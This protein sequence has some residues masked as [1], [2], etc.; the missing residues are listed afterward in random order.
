MLDVF[1]AGMLV[2]TVKLCTVSVWIHH[3]DKYH[4][5]FGSIRLLLFIKHTKTPELIHWRKPG[6]CFS[7]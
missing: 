5:F 7:C 2:D 1:Y 3:I 6:G 4:V